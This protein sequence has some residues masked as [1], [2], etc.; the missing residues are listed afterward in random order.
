[1]FGHTDGSD[2]GSTTTVG[3][4]KGFVQVQVRNIAAEFARLRESDQSI[5]VRTVDVNLATDVV[6]LL[7]NLDDIDVVDASG[8]WVG[9]HDR[10]DAV[11]VFLQDLVE[12][13]GVG[14]AVGGRF[15]QDDLQSS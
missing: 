15:D 14:R 4:G 13:F 1:M 10:C 7:A 3:D 6:D 5:E 9:N 8:G 11:A 12:V 2:T